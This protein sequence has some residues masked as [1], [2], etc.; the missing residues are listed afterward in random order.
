M[1]E[2]ALTSPVVSRAKKAAD[3]WFT[4]YS[5]NI[6]HYHEM[7]DFVA[8]GEQWT[9]KD[10]SG[11]ESTGRIA[12][13]FNSL[14]KVMRNILG[15]QQQTTPDLQVIAI[16]E[17]VQQEETNLLQ[18]ILKTICYSSDSRSA[19]QSAF[20]QDMVGG[21]GAIKATY[22]YENDESFS[23][24][25][26]IGGDT[27]PTKCFWDISAKDGDKGDGAF[28]GEYVSMTTS[29]FKAM[30]PKASTSSERTEMLGTSGYM[31]QNKDSVMVIDYY[32]KS[33][34][35]K[36]IYLLDDGSTISKKEYDG[37][38]KGQEIRPEIINRREI[39]SKKIKY[40]RIGGGEVLES[41]EY[42]GN[43]LPIRFGAH[44]KIISKGREVTRSFFADAIG[45]Q[46]LKN[47]LGSKI[48]YDIKAARYDQFTGPIECIEG[49]GDIYK[50]PMER[51]GYLPYK[52]IIEGGAIFKPERL[53]PPEVSQSVMHK[54]EQSDMD[55]MNVIG[56]YETQLGANGSEVSGAA[57]D[58]RTRQGNAGTYP[59]FNSLNI[60][61]QSVANVI[62]NLIPKV[63]TEQ[64]VMT[65]H[66]ESPTPDTTT[67]NKQAEYGI[68]NEIRDNKYEIKIVPS[69]NF[70]AQKEQMLK[71]LLG[72]LQVAP[73]LQKPDGTT[74]ATFQVIG[75]L[76][77][78]SLNI[79]NSSEIKNR[80]SAFVPQDI[81]D[82][83]KGKP[84]PPPHP[85]PPN[86]MLMMQQQHMQQ[87]M[88]LKMAELET[89]KEGLAV[90]QQRLNLEA[91]KTD[92]ELQKTQA[93]T[94]AE[95][96]KA[97]LGVDEARAH[98]DAKHHERITKVHERAIKG[99]HNILD[100][101]NSL[102]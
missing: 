64:R 17:G 26:K 101:K 68:L 41:F 99:A 58:A 67:I 60:L 4:F 10:R 1:S 49:Y 76:I 11:L 78:G 52:P 6:R 19:F 46:K 20:M 38:Y 44:N 29:D 25:V 37:L 70:E 90:Q 28:C 97:Q 51:L 74:I 16:T 85:Q 81:K 72:L 75:D 96:T 98:A 39:L 63:Y 3:K 86:P 31:Y 69:S 93:Q 42:L 32:E 65:L 9:E 47:Y 35:K 80:L 40:Y 92:A 22:D 89:K 91:F 36:K 8:H 13:V 88:Q 14:A 102:T 77:G 7:F 61:I 54:F 50:N 56:V 43:M 55:I 2:D 23:K 57:I 73:Q 87:D 30:Y 84:L 33:S 62:A 94:T 53:Q 45:P 71:V 21:F 27:D 15:Q 48:A 82:A 34:K 95:I 12:L 5:E 18:S 83:G 24:C 66:S 79:A 100:P 59:L